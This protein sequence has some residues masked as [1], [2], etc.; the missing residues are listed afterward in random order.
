MARR[1]ASVTDHV[2]PTADWVVSDRYTAH[3]RHLTP[4]TEFRVEGERG[5]FLFLR[6]VINGDREWI[7]AK[8]PVGQFRSFRVERVRTVHIK[9]RIR[10]NTKEEE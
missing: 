3:G 4:G 8:S 6:H 10:G 2:D 9:K 5:R 1:K 7:D